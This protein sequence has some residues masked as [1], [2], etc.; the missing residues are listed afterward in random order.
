MNVKQYKVDKLK[1]AEKLNPEQRSTRLLKEIQET[2]HLPKL[3]VHIE[4]F[5]NS[6]IQGSDAVAAC[7]VFKMAKPSKKDYRKYNIKTVV[8][9]DDYAC[10]E[11]GRTSPLPACHRRRDS[12]ARPDHHRR[13]K[14]ANGS[15]TRSDPGRTAL[16]YSDCRA[17]KRREN[18]GLRN[19][20]SA[21]LPKRS[22]CRYKVSCS[23]SSR[24]YRT[25]CIVSPSL[26][27]RIS[28]AK[29]RQNPNWIR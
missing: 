29:A 20:C 17:G 27:I 10:H 14:G 18:A 12:P 3:P 6:N 9:P 5:D 1:Q 21:S 22:A 7:V 11:R 13:W 16:G 19:S 8:G 23:N 24:K 25:R 4:C 2:L 15:R 26:S 28:A